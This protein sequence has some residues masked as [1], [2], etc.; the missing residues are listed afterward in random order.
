M[1]IS[2][3]AF[4]PKGDDVGNDPDEFIID[5]FDPKEEGFCGVLLKGE[6]VRPLI[7]DVTGSWGG[8]AIV[9][10]RGFNEL[11]F[12]ESFWNKATSFPCKS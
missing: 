7:E 6:F 9:L 3:F 4:I 12:F 8:V 11:Y 10:S 1:P 5:G 2:W